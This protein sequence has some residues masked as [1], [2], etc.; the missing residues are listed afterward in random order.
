M[1]LRLRSA[2]ILGTM[3][4]VVAPPLAITT[5]A[6]VLTPT[7]AEAQVGRVHRATRRRTAVVVHTHDM[8]QAA[9]QQQQ[10]APP[11]QQQAPPPQ[12]QSRLQQQPDAEQTSTVV[13]SA[14]TAGELVQVVSGES[15]NLEARGPPEAVHPAAA[16]REP[17][18]G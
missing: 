14:A 13:A 4:A 3:L 2:G 6:V 9:A 8:N 11:P 16:A 1:K 7:V 18:S 15:A 10:Q 12:E 5:V 17:R